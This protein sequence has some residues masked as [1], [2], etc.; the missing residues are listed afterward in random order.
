MKLFREAGSDFR[1]GF[2]TSDDVTTLD[3]AAPQLLVQSRVRLDGLENAVHGIVGGE[4]DCSGGVVVVDHDVDVLS[5]DG[6]DD[7]EEAE[8]DALFH[9]DP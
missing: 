4:V 5:D 8:D 7:D 3:E 6:R 2:E 1:N 9:V